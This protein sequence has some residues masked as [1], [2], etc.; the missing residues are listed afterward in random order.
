[1]AAM[2]AQSASNPSSDGDTL[3]QP[4]PTPAHGSPQGPMI[5]S[6]RQSAISLSSLHR[7]NVPLKL[8]LSS[9]SMRMTA[10]DFSKGLVPSPVSLAPKSA[11]PTSTAD[12]DL[13]AAFAAANAS[14]Q[15]VDIDLT[16]DESPT[17][18]M[19]GINTTLGNSADEPI[20]LD[21]DGIDMDMSNMTEIF[22]DGP[23]TAS[24]D[25][26]FTP[27]TTDA[28][29]SLAAGDGTNLFGTLQGASGEQENG[30]NHHGSS[31]GNA[32]S[33]PASLLASFTNQSQL[34]PAG[35]PFDLSTLDFSHLGIFGGPNSDGAFGMNMEALLSIP[36][37]G[38]RSEEQRPNP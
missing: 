3:M 15:H 4:P 12:I 37:T 13:M 29:T 1:M 9:S 7:P 17:T 22:G 19:T 18:M 21:L 16:V 30:R 36:H 33:S 31:A 27:T 11:R 5:P 14:S 26:L 35:A 28:G 6:R 2:A 20:E 38:N 8:D 23:D 10:E 25:G 32:T 34:D 24:A